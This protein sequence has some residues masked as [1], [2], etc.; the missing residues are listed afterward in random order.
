MTYQP[1][2]LG[3]VGINAGMDDIGNAL[4][5]AIRH[6]QENQRMA[7]ENLK[8]A[9]QQKRQGLMD[10][11]TAMAE[12]SKLWQQGDK[13]GAAAIMAPYGGQ[14]E[15][16][17]VDAPKDWAPKLNQ[18]EID[19]ADT[20]PMDR[21]GGPTGGQ[22]QAPQGPVDAISS[23]TTGSPEGLDA[24][25]QRALPQQPNRLVA[26]SQA[27]AKQSK[28]LAQRI[29]GKF[30]DGTDWT[31]DPDQGRRENSARADQAFY[32]A[33]GEDTPEAEQ[34]R[35]QYPQLRATYEAAG[36][37][38]DPKQVFTQFRA[39]AAGRRQEE[40]ANEREKMRLDAEGRRDA[41]FYEHNAV[42]FE[43]QKEIARIRAQA[44]AAEKPETGEGLKAEG[45]TQRILEAA[46]VMDTLPPVD[47]KDRDVI[48]KHLAQEELYE[49]NPTLR[50]A[51]QT[52]GAYK[53]LPEKLS[54]QGN[55]YWTQMQEVG[56]A[57]L[58]KES[59]A[60]ISAE[61]WRN[62]FMRYAPVR[63][64]SDANVAQKRRNMYEAARALANESRKGGAK[65]KAEV[66]KRTGKTAPAS[67]EK[68]D[69]ERYRKMMKP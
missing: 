4:T 29:R 32:E 37:N 64:E 20:L 27:Q 51:A 5:R 56:A 3:N 59:G 63:G 38:I 52:V 46:S 28:I 66:D 30:D 55:Q 2:Q 45:Q 57:I 54:E 13:A 1:I 22:P 7:A 33:S 23:P 39:D 42:T 61:E 16:Y 62:I 68:P 69:I 6:Y 36:Q 41:R 19:Y 48:L 9:G 60:A 21:P 10:R 35:E 49:K 47:A 53:T 12:A 40:A 17:E 26:A 58:R 50:V 14:M 11:Q 43:Q 67:S 15:Q 24:L 31:L 65:L 44:Q 18:G 34:I 25:M 8:N